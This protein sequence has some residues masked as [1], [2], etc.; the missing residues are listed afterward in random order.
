MPWYILPPD[1]PNLCQL[2]PLAVFS[3]AEG[4]QSRT[5]SCHP[6]FDGPRG[7]SNDLSTLSEMQTLFRY[8]R[9]RGI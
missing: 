4:L 6:L 3:Q 9:D 1:K 7:P 5:L 2:L 8:I